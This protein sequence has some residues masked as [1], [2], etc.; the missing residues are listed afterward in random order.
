MAP[1][2]ITGTGTLKN[3]VYALEEDKRTIHICQYRSTTAGATIWMLSISELIFLS[4]R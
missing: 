4:L 2:L 1:P 3:S